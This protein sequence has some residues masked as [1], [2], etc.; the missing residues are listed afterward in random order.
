VQIPV[1]SVHFSI[2]TRN[3]YHYQR[4]DHRS[5]GAY[6]RAKLFLL[7][8]R[9]CVSLMISSSY[10]KMLSSAF[11]IEALRPPSFAHRR[12]FAS[13]FLIARS[14]VSIL[15]QILHF[16]LS[17]YVFMVRRMPQVSPVRYSFEQCCLKWLHFQQSQ[18]KQL[19]S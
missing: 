10:R 8:S 18:V 2:L 19:M 12:M 5:L 17:L 3:Q 14:F 6:H 15:V 16:S 1:T 9:S 7:V 4:F 13:S 11:S